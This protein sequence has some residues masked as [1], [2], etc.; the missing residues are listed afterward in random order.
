M[1]N[2]KPLGPGHAYLFKPAKFGPLVLDW[3]LCISFMIFV[4]DSC[5]AA[6]IPL[7]NLPKIVSNSMTRK[8]VLGHVR[9]TVCCLN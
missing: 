8:K 7:K 1:W 3:K 4:I 5:H 2:E 6:K 9:P